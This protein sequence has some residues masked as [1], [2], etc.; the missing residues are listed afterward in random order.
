MSNKCNRCNTEVARVGYGGKL[1]C[2]A[3]Y[4]Q[5]VKEECPPLI[6]KERI[7][8]PLTVGYMTLVGVMVQNYPTPSGNCCSLYDQSAKK[9]YRCRNMNAENVEEAAKRWPALAA[10]VE[11][12][13]YTDN[14]IRVIDPNLP[15]SWRKHECTS[16]GYF[17]P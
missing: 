11:A 1:L 16:C 10:G 2:S 17:E 8:V 13:L 5:T 12:I 6:E 3:C 14:S 7:K 4:K 15:E 9:S